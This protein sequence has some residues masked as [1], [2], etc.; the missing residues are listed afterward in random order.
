MHAEQVR[1]KELKTK[2][3]LGVM[4]VTRQDAAFVITVENIGQNPIRIRAC[5]DSG[6][7]SVLV[8]GSPT[9]EF[10]L[11]KGLRQ[12]D[13]FFHII[14]IIAIEAL[15]IAMLEARENT[16][17]KVASGLKVNL[18]K[19]R[20]I[21]VGPQ[22]EEARMLSFG[23]RLVLIK[24][25]M[26]NMPVYFFSLYRALCKVIK[27]LD[28]GVRIGSLD[29][30]NISLL[31]KWWWRWKNE[32]LALWKQVIHA[33]HGSI[34]GESI[35][36]GMWAN[37]K[38]LD[39]ELQHHNIPLKSLF[40]QLVEK[41]DTVNLW[42]DDWF[43]DFNLA[44]MF[45]R[46]Y[47]LEIEKDFPLS[48]RLLRV[49][50]SQLSNLPDSWRWSLQKS[51]KFTVK[52]LRSRIEKQMFQNHIHY[53]R[54]SQLVPNKGISGYE[55]IGEERSHSPSQLA[56]KSTRQEKQR[57]EGPK[58]TNSPKQREKRRITRVSK[59]TRAF[60]PSRHIR[61]ER[62]QQAR[63]QT[64]K[65]D[66]EMLHMKEDEIIDTFTAKLTTLLNKAAS[67][68]HTIEDETLVQKL[69]NAIPDRT[70]P[71]VQSNLVKEDLETTLLMAILDDEEQKVSLHEEDVG[72]KETNKDSLWYLDNG[73]SNHMTGSN[74]LSLG[75]FTEIGCKV[76]MEDDELRLY[77]M[78]NKIFMKVT[79]QR[80]RLYKANL[81]IDYMSEHI[82]DEPEWTD[83]KIGNPEVTN[84]HHDQGF[85][86][87]EEDNEFPN[88]DDDD[89]ASP[90]RDSPTHSQTPHT[91]STRSSE[92]LLLAK[93]ELKNYKE[94]SSD[95]KRI[96]AMKAELDSIN[97]NNTWKLTTLPKGHKIIG[98]KWVFK[99]KRDANGNIIKHKARLLAK[100]Y[101]Q[102]H[103][104]DCEEVFAPVARM[105]TI[106]LL[107][108]I[109]AN[110]KWEVHHLDVKYAFLHEDLKEEVYVT[111]PEGFVKK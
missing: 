1:I 21:G 30:C 85:Q 34:E 8:N 60:N 98:L 99:T 6:F 23:G 20:L 14:F 40:T 100:G 108:T 78:D 87:I 81:R 59:D 75:Q 9:P 77:D 55:H 101:I 107:L 19:S 45:P 61:E 79:R 22:E 51:G 29:A 62:V 39:Q 67:L 69:L 63:L 10:K 104:I 41:G 53:T 11:S 56:N 70:K 57:P 58:E 64:L 66:F 82:N 91:P 73:A 26:S 103:S 25:V 24:S 95:Q 3:S 18:S 17:S 92:E 50:G 31:A 37:I 76:V 48:E 38:K 4:N 12:G 2:A 109:A 71:N 33:I 54:W 28:R 90:T 52:S 35:K 84:E 49:D 46:L 32:D 102:E 111:Q 97:R 68:G 86:P 88:N 7:S 94:A 47:T 5:L 42:K 44:S 83:F 27:S 89:Y 43:G 15:H 65:S 93:D 13:P 36:K 110:N 16:F 96:E 74:I 80:N 105:E 72:Y 106:R